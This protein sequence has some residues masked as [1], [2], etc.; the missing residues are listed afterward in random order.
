MEISF[1]SCINRL[2]I[3]IYKCT[4]YIYVC[5]YIN[6][7]ITYFYTYIPLQYIYYLLFVLLFLF[8]S[9]N[10]KLAVNPQPGAHLSSPET[11]GDSTLP[12]T[13]LPLSFVPSRSVQIQSL[14]HFLRERPAVLVRFLWS[15]VV[16]PTPLQF[17]MN[18][19]HSLLS[20]SRLRDKS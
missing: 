20:S 15:S 4:Y 14:V 3:V 9:A 8:P 19:I 17:L 16:S 5:V 11:K 18:I 1:H 6:L 13:G 2:R 12:F 10:R 7:F